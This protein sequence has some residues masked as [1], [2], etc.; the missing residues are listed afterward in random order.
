M[1]FKSKTS[2]KP[3]TEKAVGLDDLPSGMIK[4]AVSVLAA[5]LEFFINL[6]LLSGIVPSAQK[7]AKVIP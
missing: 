7:A 5:P 3:K 1:C 6:S 4:D 2:L